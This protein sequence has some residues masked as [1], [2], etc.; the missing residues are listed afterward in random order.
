MIVVH[1]VSHVALYT[2]SAL[3]SPAKFLDSQLRVLFVVSL[4]PRVKCQVAQIATLSFPRLK[5][6]DLTELFIAR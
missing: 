2:I 3:T 1:S 4:W 5:V 6:S